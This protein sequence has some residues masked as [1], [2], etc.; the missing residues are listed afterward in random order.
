[1]EIKSCK[2]RYFELCAHQKELPLFVQ[3]HWMDLVCTRGDWEIRFI[4][5]NEG[6]LQAIWPLYRIQ[7]FGFSRFVRPILTPSFGPLFVSDGTFPQRFKEYGHRK[8]VLDALIQSLPHYDYFRVPLSPKTFDTQPLKWT[9]FK[10]EVRYTYQIQPTSDMDSLIA[11]WSPKTLNHIRHCQDTLQ[12]TDSV[13]P[14]EFFR[15][16]EATFRRQKFPSPYDLQ[17]ITKLYNTLKEKDQVKI[18][19]AHDGDQVQAAA[20]FVGDQNTFFLLASGY[21]D[22]AD[23]GAM[24]LVLMEG[25]KMAMRAG[26]VFDFEGSDIPGIENYYRGFGGELIPYY[27][28][29]HVPNWFLR[30]LLFFMNRY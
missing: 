28:V 5:S 19:G 25:I 24:S 7:K 8:K 18:L 3:P 27:E 4:E 10:T 15:I 30:S 17:F 22:G 1:M 20:L 11:G 21:I 12:V 29:I 2:I 14:E 6:R 16:N 23:R 13:T 26:R 9:G